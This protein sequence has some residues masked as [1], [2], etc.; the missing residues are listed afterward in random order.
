M[1]KLLVFI[2]VAALCISSQAVAIDFPKGGSP[3]FFKSPT[4]YSSQFFNKILGAYNLQLNAGGEVPFTYAKVANGKANFN[5]LPIAYTPA[6]YHDI[7]TSYGLQLSVANAK[8]ILMVGTYAKVVDDRVVFGNKPIAY[9]G[10]E[11]T[12]I[13]E[14]YSLPVAPI[15][16]SVAK[17]VEAAPVVAKPGDDDGDGVTNDKD[18]CPGTPRYAAVDERGCW[19]LSSALLFDFDKSIIKAQFYSLLDNT[20]KV[21]DEFPMMKVVVEGHADSKGTDVYNQKLSQRRAQAVVDYLTEKV[22]I[23]S[24]RLKAVGY[25]ESKPAYSNDTEAGQAKNRRV[26][27]S[28]MN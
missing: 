28:P 18:A 2:A 10:S 25:G 24:N 17:K 7:L 23:A 16:K 3:S 14:A 9:G 19:A 1:R 15:V 4:A 13:L 5:A 21:F 26:Q 20:K 11:W 27:F 8:E 12:N 22:G 6:Q